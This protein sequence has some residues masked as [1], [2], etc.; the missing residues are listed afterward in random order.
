MGAVF[1][2]TKDGKISQRNFGGHEYPRLAHVGDRAGLEM[3]RTRPGARRLLVSYL[4]A[5]SLRCPASNVAGVTGKR[6]SSAYGVSAGPARR[7]TPG[8]PLVTHPAEMTAQHRV[9]VPECQQLSVLRPVP[10]EH[11]DSEAE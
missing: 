1:D 2:R 3:I 7:T 9:L 8:R 11:Q 4:F 5:A 6:R 10:A